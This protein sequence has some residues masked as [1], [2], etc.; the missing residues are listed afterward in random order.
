MNKFNW[1][2]ETIIKGIKTKGSL[3][4]KALKHVFEELDWKNFVIQH[5]LENGGQMT[6]AKEVALDTLI[7][8]NRNVRKDSFKG[9]SKLKTYFIGIAKKIWLKQ[10]RDRKIFDEIKIEHYEKEVES[11]EY[12][13][14]NEENK[15]YWDILLAKIGER[16]KTILKLQQ[17]DYSLKEIAKEVSLSND[18]MAKKEA[19]RCRMKMRKLL[20]DNPSWK[21]LI[22]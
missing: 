7:A 5:V 1:T 12:H 2:E 16:C 20:K 3:G 17:L 10:I 14:I 4:D 18:K 13:L 21:D 11:I 9:N 22:Q 15:R 6:D 19:Y 8:F